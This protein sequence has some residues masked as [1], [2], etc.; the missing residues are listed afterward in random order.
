MKSWQVEFTSGEENLG[1][2]NIRLGIFQGDSFSPLLFVV[3]LFPLTQILRDATPGYHFASNRQ[4]VN[5]LFLM[6]EL[7][8][9]A[10]NGKLYCN[11]TVRVFSNDMEMKFGVEKCA[12]L[13]MKNGK[14]AK[15]D[16]TALPNK[17]TMKGLKQDDSYKY[18]GVIQADRM[19]HHEMLEKVKTEYYRR[20]IKIL[21]M[22]LNGGN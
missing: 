15:S 4:K 7:K 5:H 16:G 1:E 14:M 13:A 12:V 6:N 18:L 19:K 11:Q 22:K 8:L 20:V 3:Y 10:S 9:Y 21:E 2:V 17:T